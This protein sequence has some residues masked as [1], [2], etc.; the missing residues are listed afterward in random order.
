[1]VCVLMLNKIYAL[2]TEL[3]IISFFKLFSFSLYI[4]NK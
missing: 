1:V 2:G 4:Q 3:V